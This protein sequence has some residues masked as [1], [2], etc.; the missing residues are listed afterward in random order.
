M[1]MESFFAV[2]L[3]KGIEHRKDQ[4]GVNFYEGKSS[5]SEGRLI[6]Q[7][8][9]HDC[10]AIESS[11]ELEYQFIGKYLLKPTVKEGAVITV[12]IEGCLWY[13][14]KDGPNLTNLF[15][16]FL[17]EDWQL[18]HPALGYAG[19][20]A[21]KFTV[22]LLNFYKKKTDEFLTKYGFLFNSGDCLP[23]KY[24]YEKIGAK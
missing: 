23:G 9:S 14:E 24:F 20:N 21:E 18:F 3:P 12:N 2:A 16:F 1:G 5:L 15:R 7:L 22:G 6:D 4:F 11:N 8:I 10:K 19:N 17:N 13:L